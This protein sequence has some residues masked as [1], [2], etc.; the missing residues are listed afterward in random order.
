MTYLKKRH[1]NNYSFLASV[2]YKS[3]TQWYDVGSLLLLMSAS[4]GKSK[5]EM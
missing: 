1:K 5:G 3:Y 4:L 2:K